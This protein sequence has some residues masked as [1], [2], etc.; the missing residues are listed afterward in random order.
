MNNAAPK[1]TEAETRG[2]KLLHNESSKS[3]TSKEADAGGL[4]GGLRKFGGERSGTFSHG[5]V[6]P[7]R[8]DYP[9]DKDINGNMIDYSLQ[10]NGGTFKETYLHKSI[11]NV[12]IVV[13]ERRPG[14]LFQCMFKTMLYI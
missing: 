5:T 3:G 10:K 2:K 7:S 6:W 1:S 4:N 11:I 9:P 12:P 8:K 13:E 14:K